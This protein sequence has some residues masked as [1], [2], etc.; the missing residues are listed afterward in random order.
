VIAESFAQTT[1]PALIIAGCA[2]VI[3]VTL[4]LQW[5][6]GR[7]RRPADP[8]QLKRWQDDWGQTLDQWLQGI[9]AELASLRTSPFPDT[10]TP[11]EEPLGFSD[12]VESC[13]DGPLQ[14]EITELRA[15]GDL[16]L[17]TARTTD[18]NGPETAAAEARY[19]ARRNAA[20][21]RLGIA[22]G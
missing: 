6:T 12:A 14:Q 3:A 2:L 4:F 16:M 13:P 9:E 22:A 17:R 19:E 21:A 10:V 11:T 18:P 1:L 20:A 7:R 8:G 15:A 5:R